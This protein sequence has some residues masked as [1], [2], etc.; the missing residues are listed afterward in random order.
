MRDPPDSESTLDAL[1][2]QLGEVVLSDG[3]SKACRFFLSGDQS[4]YQASVELL[5]E[6][7]AI[8]NGIGAPLQANVAYGI[9]SVLPLMMR[10]STWVQLEQHSRE[11]EVWK[12]YLTLLARPLSRGVTELW[13]SQIRVL[14]S[15][16]LGSDDS[17]VVRLP[18]SGGKTRIAEM[19]II[20]TFQ[21]HSWSQVCICCS[22]SCSSIRSR[23]NL[24]FSAE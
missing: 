12:R 3:L 6:A 10:R 4:A 8:F 16:F 17:A 5:H 20:D 14:D 7:T 2:L 21:R 13:P 23:T 24:R 18:T 19:A 11:S 1:S 15:G 22:L 9:R